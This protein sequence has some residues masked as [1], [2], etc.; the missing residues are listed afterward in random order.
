VPARG[1][2]LAS[3]DIARDVGRLA[4]DHGVDL[5][6]L[7]AP[8]LGSGPLAPELVGLFER[9]PADVAL[10]AGATGRGDRRVLVAFAGGEHDWA[11]L[12]VGAWLAAA[13]DCEL[14]LVGPDADGEGGASRAL[15]AASLAVQRT[16]GIDAVPLLASAEELAGAAEGARA[17]ICGV[18][19]GWR[20]GGLGAV[21]GGLVRAAR[22]PVLI[23]H[24]GPRP[25][26]L[27]PAG[28]DTRFTWSLG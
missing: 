9:C 1:A 19:L 24:R 17:V 25:G 4:E 15:A 5:V 6:L 11:A 20:R 27:A 8:Q 14:V 21:R 28:S 16:V 18:P 12:E 2:A 7:D 10:V 23:V 13:G 26:G 22:A 3:A